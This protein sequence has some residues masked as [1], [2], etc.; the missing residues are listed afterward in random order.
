MALPP[1]LEDFLAL[2]KKPNGKP[3]SQKII[4]EATGKKLRVK[5]NKGGEFWFY[6]YGRLPGATNASLHRLKGVTTVD[7]AIKR[8]IEI[9]EAVAKEENPFDKAT[10]GIYCLKDCWDLALPNIEKTKKESTVKD[11]KDF[12]KNWLSPYNW[13]W[14]KKLDNLTEEDFKRLDRLMIKE[15]KGLSSRVKIKK[16]IG[17]MLEVIPNR[18]LRKKL[19]FELNEFK[20][21]KVSEESSS[22]HLEVKL[23]GLTLEEALQQWIDSY[24]KLEE[25]FPKS[26][27][28][29]LKALFLLHMASARRRGQLAQTKVG[30]IDLK[31]RIIKYPPEA[32][33]GNKEDI[34]HIPEALMGILEPLMEG[35]SESDY[36][37]SNSWR[38]AYNILFKIFNKCVKI[39][40]DGS[41]DF[42]G[43]HDMRDIFVT[44]LRR[45]GFNPDLIFV[46]NGKA[47][48][49]RSGRAEYNHYGEDEILNVLEKWW[50]MSI[51]R[52]E[53]TFRA[54]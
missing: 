3:Y 16:V 11:Y 28:L 18:E 35:K 21:Q 27:S 44:L 33:K 20:P 42:A 22:P 12:V 31:R 13:L 52:I 25:C 29:S 39:P 53:Y 24:K 7:Q 19:K 49:L 1:K 14:K 41:N 48:E 6:W 36:L 47:S 32:V 51:D 23:K 2:N 54:L 45:E 9:N 30:W 40:I 50:A 38:T 34:V 37:F 43:S 10:R 46:A 8:A 17:K 5:L 4:R 26:D 15:G